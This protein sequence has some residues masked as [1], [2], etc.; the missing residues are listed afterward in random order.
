MSGQRSSSAIMVC[1]DDAPPEQERHTQREAREMEK[2]EIPK[3]LRPVFWDYQTAPH[4]FYQ[5]ADGERPGIGQKRSA[6]GFLFM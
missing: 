2:K 1:S 6:P 4:T 5:I 3:L